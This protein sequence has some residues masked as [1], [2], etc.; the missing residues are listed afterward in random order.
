MEATLRPLYLGLAALL[1]SVPALAQQNQSPVSCRATEQEVLDVAHQLW[2][3]VRNRDVAAYDKLVDDDFISTDD[4]AVRKGKKEILA[5]LR[6]PEGNIHNETD[7]QPADIRLVFTDGVAI[8]NFSKHWTDYD[9]AAGI[10][11]G[12]SSVITRVFTC[13][14]GE[15]KLISFHETGISNRDRQPSTSAM[16]HL[17]DY[18]GRY[19]LG[20]N[21]D[22]GEISVARTGDK[23]FETWPGDKPVEILPGKYDTFFTRVDLWVERFVRDESGKVTGI[24]YT[25]PDGEIE[26]KRIP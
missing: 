24:L 3:A 8:L 22:K 18:V 25:Y 2:S 14:N 12:G 26:A 16:S 6:Q 11:F 9:K 19:R 1:C 4:G 13:K 23:L 20:E 15:W 10:S 21:G 7:E 17:D 5:G